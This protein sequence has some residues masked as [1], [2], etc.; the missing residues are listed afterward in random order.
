MSVR[1][2][3]APLECWG[4]AGLLLAA[5]LALATPAAACDVVVETPAAVRIEYNPFAVGASSGPVDVVFHNRSDTACALQLRLVDDVGDPL[6]EVTLGGAV[7]GFRPR[8]ASGLL[9][10]DI[11]RGAFV[12]N[13]APDSTTRAEMDA[14]VLH[15]AVVEAGQHQADLR[16]LIQSADG[17]PA[18][19]PVPLRVI[20]QSAPRAQV[21]IAGASGAFGSGS[22]V[23]VIDFG[24][25]ATGVTRRAFLQVRANTRSTV[26][27]RSEHH[28]VMRHLEM[29]ETGSVVAYQLELD[30]DP[31]DLTQVWTRSVDPP[32]T[33][34]GIDFP[35]DFTLGTISGQMSGRYEDLVTIDITP[36]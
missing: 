8:E 4:L 31:V 3:P 32:R 26:S 18:P 1:Y 23:E 13:L 2:T 21:N 30:G 27:I 6:P 22:S 28:G 14:V 16:L 19:P 33:L 34:A 7:V 12:L 10:S 25:A 11:E 17:E 36:N 9:R 20:L 15:D 5:S 35:L 29:E 24:L